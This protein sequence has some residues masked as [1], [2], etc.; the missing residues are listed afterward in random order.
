[1]M[2]HDGLK[3]DPRDN[4]TGNLAPTLQL[5][6]MCYSHRYRVGSLALAPAAFDG[7][8]STRFPTTLIAMLQV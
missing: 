2:E 7:T 8:S 3:I 4:Y 1:M 5:V 6:T